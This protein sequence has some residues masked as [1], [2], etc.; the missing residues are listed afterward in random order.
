MKTQLLLGAAIAVLGTQP[1][2]AQAS[3]DRDTWRR[4]P[5]V[6]TGQADIVAVTE[7]STATRTPSPI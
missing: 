3:E 2:F 1:A 7:T 5:V 6:V 4:D